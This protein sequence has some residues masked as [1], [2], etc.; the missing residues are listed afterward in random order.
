MR[1]V[2]VGSFLTMLAL[3]V[4][5]AYG[6]AVPG[7]SRASGVDVS[8]V[9]Q[10]VTIHA[11]GAATGLAVWVFISRRRTTRGVAIGAVT[12]LLAGA[13]AIAANPLAARSPTG[14]AA[15]PLL[16][17]TVAVVGFAFGLG[18][19][20]TNT[21]LANTS[22]SA[23][24]L[25]AANGM[26]GLGAVILPFVVGIADLRTAAFVVAG[27]A[28]ITLPT[29]RAVPDLSGQLTASRART[30]ADR[31]ARRTSRTAPDATRSSPRDHLARLWFGNGSRPWV[32]MF[33]VAI[34]VEAGTGAWAAAHLVG[35]GISEPRAALAVSGFFATF[36]GVRFL[37]AAV[38]DRL[39]PRVV[40]VG[41]N[42]IA[43]VTAV[44]AALVPLPAY[45]WALVGLG[46]GPVFPTTLAWM[47][48]AT[49]DPDGARRMTVGGAVGSVLLP[50]SIGLLVGW[51]GPSV[52]PW[53]IATFAGATALV[54]TRLPAADQ[55]RPTTFARATSMT[56]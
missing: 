54:A 5:N 17:A 12:L 48:R 33:G 37:M 21:V 2:V 13:I 45:A 15:F 34:G 10:L 36:T 46:V 40:V 29:L 39:R 43:A 23:R 18:M 50:G 22:G 4:P 3:S 32:W 27:L 25:S 28:A 24:L 14:G 52:I 42:I 38:G 56:G 7:I 19:V 49:G 26:Y 55:P 30:V 20:A 6:A 16:V 1:S 11:I 47:T 44:L 9:G 41:C 53:A 35:R 51:A 31:A 8:V